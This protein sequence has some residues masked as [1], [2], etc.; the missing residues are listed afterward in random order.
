MPSSSLFQ[1]TKPIYVAELP[2]KK[3]DYRFKKFREL[4]TKLNI[5]KNLDE[6]VTIWNYENLDETNRIANE[7]KKKLS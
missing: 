5:I 4:F 7:I 6:K 2:P 1:S 3:N